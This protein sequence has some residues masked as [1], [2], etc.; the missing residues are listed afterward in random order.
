MGLSLLC[1]S[2]SLCQMTLP[3]PLRGAPPPVPPG[4]RRA[5]DGPRGHRRGGGVAGRL[6]RRC[7]RDSRDGGGAVGYCRVAGGRRRADHQA[8]SPPPA[9]LS[10]H[11]RPLKAPG[12]HQS[13]ATASAPLWPG[14]APTASYRRAREPGARRGQ[15]MSL[16]LCLSL[17]LSLC[18]SALPHPPRGGFAPC[19]PPDRAVG[20][21]W[22]ARLPA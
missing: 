22:P 6:C 4:Q 8:N 16:S 20:G 18:S 21:P 15:G 13:P 9:L 3:P 10:G 5:G 17:P 2:L 12:S 1:V 14:S 19:D 7:G 11:S